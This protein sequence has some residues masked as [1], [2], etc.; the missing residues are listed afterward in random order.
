[1]DLPDWSIGRIGSVVVDNELGSL[2]VRSTQVRVPD[3]AEQS[4]CQYA[5]AVTHGRV[6]RLVAATAYR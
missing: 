2:D 3:L 4:A 6:M 1:L 5:G